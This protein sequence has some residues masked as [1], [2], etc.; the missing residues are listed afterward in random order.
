MNKLFKILKGGIGITLLLIGAVTGVLISYFGL[1]YLDGGVYVLIN[2]FLVAF[3][4]VLVLGAC[5]F[6]LKNYFINKLFGEDDS[7]NTA[8]Q[9]A[10]EITTIF[11]K[12]VAEKILPYEDNKNRSRLILLL[13]KVVSF[14]VWG[15]IRRWWLSILVG[16]LLGIGGLATTSL[17]LRQNRLID[18][19]NSKI[20]TQNAL[21]EGQRRSSLVLLLGNL[22]T[23]ISREIESQKTDIDARR[24]DSLQNNGYSLSDPLVG[25]I[26]SMTQGFLSYK[27]LVNGR[28]TKREV[29]IEKGQL[30]LA[31][32]GSN[33]DTVTYNKIYRRTAFT[34]AY[35]RGSNLSQYYLKGIRLGN[36]DLTYSN[37]TGAN[38]EG[39]TLVGAKLDTANFSRGNFTRCNFSNCSLLNSE[40]KDATFE[41]AEFYAADLT[42]V[43]L[44]GTNFRNAKF[45]GSKLDSLFFEKQPKFVSE[46]TLPDKE[47]NKSIRT[48]ATISFGSNDGANLT[49]ASFYSCS[50]RGTDFGKVSLKGCI[51]SNIDFSKSYYY[52]LD[53][54]LK[55]DIVYNCTFFKKSH[56]EYLRTTKPCLSSS[57]GCYE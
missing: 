18:V 42:K 27:M 45:T 43:L 13:P 14:L 48:R 39:A 3:F 1:E 19:Q 56:D 57:N 25:K 32:L 31:L 21:L 46:G 11:S 29:S 15:R 20:E 30:L 4:I 41:S 50:F 35:L 23:E 2:T 9:D 22:L 47:G 54:F 51:F 8:I 5:L 34:N 55:C 12:S 53:Q 28:L 16:I 37:L 7:I 10:Q 24:L 49:K 38:F 26:A 17:L 44:D 33:L 36:A 6:L 40:L 52:T